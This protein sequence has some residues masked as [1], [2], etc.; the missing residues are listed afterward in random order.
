MA[1]QLAQINIA[2]L[3]APIDSPLLAD[4]VADLDRINALA[5]NSPGF[6]WRLKDDS[7]NAT[8][9]NPYHDN[10]IIVNIS[11]WENPDVLRQFVYRSDHV[12]VFM[13][14]AKWFERPVEAHMALWWVPAG[15]YPDAAEGK[16]KLDY[17]RAHGETKQVFS[18]KKMFEK[19]A[20]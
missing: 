11:V 1:Y 20:E 18:F 17:L 16:N 7:G 8:G 13:K 10:T 12:E 4:F 3:L 15:D 19:P 6:V 5:E 9:F 2:K 14:R